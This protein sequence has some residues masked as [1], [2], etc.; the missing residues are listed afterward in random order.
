MCVWGLRAFWV[1]GPGVSVFGV[2]RVSGF[3]GL[4]VGFRV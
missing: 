4:R 3:R 1:Q 2:S